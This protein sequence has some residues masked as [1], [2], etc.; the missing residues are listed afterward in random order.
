MRESI[1]EEIQDV[2]VAYEKATDMHTE[3]FNDIV[4]RSPFRLVCDHPV[5]EPLRAHDWAATPELW[6]LLAERASCFKQSRIVA[7]G[8]LN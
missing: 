3:L 6:G 1:L 8:F 5:V 2:G 7:N 4:S